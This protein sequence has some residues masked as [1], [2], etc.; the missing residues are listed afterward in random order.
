MHST[1][2]KNICQYTSIPNFKTPQ[3]EYYGHT[4]AFTFTFDNEGLLLKVAVQE[5]T[6]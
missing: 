5:V 4:Y 6:E 2:Y 3:Y 1:E